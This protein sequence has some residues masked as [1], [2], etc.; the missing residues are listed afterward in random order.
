[1]NA[2]D[3][4]QGKKAENRCKMKSMFGDRGRLNRGCIKMGGNRNHNQATSILPLPY[5]SVL[6]PA[7][8]RSNHFANL[9]VHI[10]FF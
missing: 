5:N 7:A 6:T 8:I 1:M 3:E 9:F 2:K 4:Y 10:S